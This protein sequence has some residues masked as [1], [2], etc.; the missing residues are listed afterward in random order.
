[1][2]EGKPISLLAKWLKKANASGEK[3]KTLGIYTAKKLG[4]SIYDYK[5]ICSRLRKYLDVTEIKMSAG[6]WDQIDYEKVPSRAM[7]IY[8]WAFYHHE[9]ERFQAYLDEVEAGTAK[10][11]S[12]TLYPYDIVEKILEEEERIRQLRQR[13]QQKQAIL[14]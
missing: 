13:Q 5:R 11:H 6:Q 4:Y 3:T 8:R 1:M 14:C 10:V 7:M 9:P 12:G 2:G